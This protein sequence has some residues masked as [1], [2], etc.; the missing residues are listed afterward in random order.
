MHMTERYRTMVT[1]LAMLSVSAALIVAWAA[2]DSIS[3]LG[4]ALVVAATAAAW[5]AYRAFGVSAVGTV[6]C[7]IQ[8]NLLI[9][10]TCCVYRA[11]CY[12]TLGFHTLLLLLGLVFAPASC[13]AFAVVAWKRADRRRNPA[14]ALVA[15]LLV[16]AV[17]F[18]IAFPV[19]IQQRRLRHLDQMSERLPVLQG[20]V[21][22]VRALEAA[23]GRIPADKTEF[24]ELVRVNDP[25]Q[26]LGCCYGLDYRRIAPS[27]F[28]LVYR[29]VDVE[30]VYDSS[31]PGDG[32]HCGNDESSW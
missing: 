1:L 16:P 21:D 13:A 15:L 23:H 5:L 10:W 27:R 14:A 26:L 25:N 7:L 11:D 22:E 6:L 4:P 19:A 29:A 30:Y 2:V 3:W 24:F 31:V 18:F 12:M 28:T 17:F 32:W 8:I 9:A 20:V